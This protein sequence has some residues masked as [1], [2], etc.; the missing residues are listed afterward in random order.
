MSNIDT[1]DL[2]ELEDRNVDVL[3]LLSEWETLVD[4]LSEKEV[5]LYQWKT[6]YQVKAMEIENNTDFKAIYGKN[7]ADIRKQHV[8]MELSEWD[9]NIHE[10]EVSI[11]WISRRISFLRELVK[12]KRTLMELKN[13]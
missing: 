13:E 1:M 5:A 7:N 6:V 2:V 8:K 9:K 12:V 4:E 10:L 11:N 3:V